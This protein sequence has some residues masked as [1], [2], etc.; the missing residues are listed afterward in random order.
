MSDDPLSE[1]IANRI[2]REI[3]RGHLAPGTRLKERETASE[4]GVSRTPMREAIRILAKEGLVILRPSRSPLVA[5]LTV[6]EV[7]EQVEVLL[8]LETLAAELACG[9]ATPAD[10]ARIHGLADGIAR[11]FDAKDPLDTFE[12]DMAF[13]SALVHAAH[14]EVLERTHRMLLERLW[15]ARYLSAVQ[16]RNRSR[17]I[18]Q[19]NAIVAALDAGDALAMRQAIHAHL[20]R[21]GTY[22]RDVIETE[23]EDRAPQ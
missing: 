9:R 4:M 3:L 17:V 13:H 20:G 2:R 18:D 7:A 10:L 15:R 22:I 14:N 11:D 23:A 1:Q 5:K 6:R 16:Q 21:L 19:H 8:A 12:V